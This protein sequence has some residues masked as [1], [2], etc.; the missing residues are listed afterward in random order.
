MSILPSF[1]FGTLVFLPLVG[2]LVY[3]FFSPADV[4]AVVWL[5]AGLG[6]AVDVYSPLVK[7]VHT[8]ALVVIVLLAERLYVRTFTNRSLYAFCALAVTGSV[9]YLAL[10]VGVSVLADALQWTTYTLPLQVTLLYQIA[11]N[12]LAGLVAFTVANVVRLNSVQRN[13]YSHWR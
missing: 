11:G 5:A 7:G 8:F 6:Y 12:T 3:V 10:I 1:G 4:H 9:V 2:L 13:S